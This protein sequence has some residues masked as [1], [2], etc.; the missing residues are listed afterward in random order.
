MEGK[1]SMARRELEFPQ[2]VLDCIEATRTRGSVLVASSRDGMNA[3]TIG[4]ITIGSVWGRPC[5]TVL[6]RPSR[7]TYRFIE[8][9]DS[10]T[11]NVLPE[12]MNEA[13]SLLGTRS[14][15]EI[16]KFTE[17]GITAAD[18]MKVQCPHI[19]EADLVIE[20]RT[21]MK[22]PIDPSLI[23]ADYV[24]EAYAAGDYHTVYFGEI[25]AIHAK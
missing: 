6:V 2:G 22:Q 23:F 17:A 25:L 8:E 20:C 5:C 19:A 14:G 21:A 7:Y 1:P 11:V 16:D 10:F 4:W 18:S 9:G 15:R 12:E 24:H 13:V 3:M